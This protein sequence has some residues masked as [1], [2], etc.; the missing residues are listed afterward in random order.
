MAI[1][2]DHEAVS[3]D[4]EHYRRVFGTE[5]FIPDGVVEDKDRVEVKANKINEDGSI[6]EAAIETSIDLGRVKGNAGSILLGSKPGDVLDVDLEE[7]LG[8][9]RDFI[10]KNTLKQEEDLNPELPLRYHIE[11]TG[12]FRP[13]STELTGEQI[14]KYVG[15][16]VEDESAFRKMLEDRDANTN[17]SRTNEMKKLAVRKA[18]LDANPFEIPEEFLLKWV[19]SQRDQKI[20][21]GSREANNLF[22]D[23][24]WSLLLNRISKDAALEVTEKDIQKQVT[25]WIIENVNYRQT[26]IRKLMKELYANEYF[27]ST[28]KEHALEE[29]VFGHII[30]QVSFVE[31]EGTMKEFEHAFHDLHHELFDHGDHS[32]HDHDHGHSHHGDHVHA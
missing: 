21:L 6:A 24:K 19:N 7:F 25:N 32:D 22:R 5:E 1:Q 9:P 23:A 11:L 12:I 18:L 14:S 16:Q 27:M 8:F 2:P 30:P 13:Q 17:L 26:D 3:K 15:Q 29:V 4:I 31:K 28:M 10:I 20:E